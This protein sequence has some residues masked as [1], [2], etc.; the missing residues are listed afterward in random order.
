MSVLGGGMKVVISGMVAEEGRGGFSMA[1]VF[2]RRMR[3]CWCDRG[4]EDRRRVR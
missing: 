1:M 4:F 3:R 2:A